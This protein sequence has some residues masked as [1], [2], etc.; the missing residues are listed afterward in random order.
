M[1]KLFGLLDKVIPTDARILIEGESG[2][3][4]E[5]IARAIHYNGPRKKGRFVAIDCG[6]LPE[7]LLESELFGHVRG[8]FTGAT[9]SKKGLFHVADGG[10]LFLDEIN[11]TSP[12]LQAKLLRAIQEGEIR[13]VGGTKTIK[14][15]VRVLCASGKNLSEAVESGTF[16]QDLFFRLNVVTVKLPPL[17]ERKE[18]IPLLANHFLNKFKRTLSKNLKGFTKATSKILLQHDWPGNVRELENAIERGAT[19]AEPQKTLIDAD[20]LPEEM[21]AGREV[22]SNLEIPAANNLPQAVKELERQMIVDALSKF[23]GNRS[24]AADSLGL[25]RRGLLNKIER[26]HL[27]HQPL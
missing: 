24:K 11:N 9:E 10:T 5:L 12:A 14:V 8:A 26:Y 21:V 1:Q 4:K 6:T 2:T 13:P 23:N 25:S 18:D 27:R 19:L 15:N 20:L 17:R 7:N 22:G 16:R 3:G